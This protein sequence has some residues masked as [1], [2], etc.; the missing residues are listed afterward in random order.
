MSATLNVR[1]GSRVRRGEKKRRRRG[2]EPIE[3]RERRHGY[4][5]KSFTWRGRRYD[6]YAVER[7]WTVSRRRRGGRVERHCFRVRCSFDPA[8]DGPFDSAQDRHE[9]TFE[10]YQD[11]R[12]NTWHLQI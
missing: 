4:F 2:A 3:M 7:C 10:V 1:R 8:Q 9:G 5:P 6:V 12:H 11:V